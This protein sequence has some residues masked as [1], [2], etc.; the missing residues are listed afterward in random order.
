MSDHIS[1][2]HLAMALAGGLLVYMG[3]K[4]V[5]YLFQ[6]DAM[7]TL[8]YHSDHE[9]Y[10]LQAQRVL[11]GGPLYQPFQ[12]AGPY[13]AYANGL[14]T[15][16]EL[17]P[18]TAVYLLFVPMSLLPAVLWWAIPITIVAVVVWHWRPG[19]WAWVF[20]LAALAVPRSWSTILTGNPVLWMTA[21]V[22]LG[23]IYGWPAI[24]VVLKPTL[25]PFALLG[26][27]TGRWWVAVLAL[28]VVSLAMLPGWLDYLTVMRNFQGGSLLYS[29][30]QYPLMAIPVVAWLGRRSV[31][32]DVADVAVHSI[33]AGDPRVQRRGRT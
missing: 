5:A 30:D 2:R 8:L 19:L 4:A 18:P 6:W 24:L 26:I 13:G 9:L 17:Y 14:E 28:G 3:V 11:D 12:L 27:N 29:L 7:M 21:F 25:A 20:I 10:M 1:S 33:L 22:A 15:W 16:P 31:E 32:L 23:T